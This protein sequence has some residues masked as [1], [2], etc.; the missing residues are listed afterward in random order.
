MDEYSLL[1][2]RSFVFCLLLTYVVHLY[3]I[4]VFA[5]KVVTP[6]TLVA[7]CFLIKNYA[8]IG[9]TL[10]EWMELCLLKPKFSS[11]CTKL[12]VVIFVCCV[13]L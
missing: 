3:F 4:Y 8:K 2:Q 13:L 12:G 7:S 10:G 11:V 6:L 5:V 9:K 1:L